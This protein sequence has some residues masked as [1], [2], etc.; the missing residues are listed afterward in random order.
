MDKPNLQPSK[1]EPKKRPNEDTS[2]Q[3]KP[4]SKSRGV[5]SEH[6]EVQ[7]D[8]T[9]STKESDKLKNSNANL[10]KK[11]TPRDAHAPKRVSKKAE[12]PK[13]PSPHQV[14]P[15]TPAPVNRKSKKADTQNVQSQKTDQRKLATKPGHQPAKQRVEPSLKQPSQPRK[16]LAPKQAAQSSKP[17]QPKKMLAPKQA[18][19]SPTPSKDAETL[20]QLSADIA[21]LEE[22]IS[23]LPNMIVAPTLEAVNSYI[24]PILSEISN[25][26]ALPNQIVGPTLEVT[27]SYISPIYDELAKLPNAIVTPTLEAVHSYIAPIQQEIAKVQ[28]MPNQILT[29]TLK[30]ISESINPVYDGIGKIPNL[31]LEPL[32]SA[33]NDGINP[34]YDEIGKIPNLVLEPLLSAV[35]DG[36]NPIYDEVGKIPNLVLEPL[37]SVVSDGINPI[38]DEIGKIPNL[39]VTPTLDAIHEYIDPIYKTSARIEQSII[40]IVTPDFRKAIFEETGSAVQSEAGSLLKPIQDVLNEV[41]GRVADDN[42]GIQLSIIEQDT[43]GPFE[44]L[45]GQSWFQSII[46]RRPKPENLLSSDDALSNLEQR[47]P[48]RYPVWKKCFDAGG[49]VYI[50]DPSNNCAHWSERRAWAFKNYVRRNACGNILDIGCGPYGDPLYLRGIDDRWLTGMEP[51][52]M[53]SETRFPIYT[54][55]NEKLPFGDHAFDTVVNSTAIDHCIDLPEAIAE[56]ARIIRPG[57]RF[58]I[59]YANVE[60][61]EDPTRPFEGALDRFHLFHNNDEWFM[62]MMSKHFRILDRKSI[63]AGEKVQ[64]VFAVFEPLH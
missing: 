26:N 41:A 18:A 44:P 57:G 34:I 7:Q 25:L 3:L 53:Q 10:G 51:L 11:T 28:G 52:P 42:A 8:R 58:V 22:K 2:S 17:S 13:K 33:V 59:W 20:R 63:R 24:A 46:N 35:N 29:P 16:T 14:K 47:F 36:I 45:K 1:S 21:A 39:V 56:T 49:E 19:Q 6:P 64:D 55:F 15:K 40:D 30:A 43:D 61:A 37:L 60:G 38:Y 12:S 48:E 50:E 4:S 5:K 32:L 9:G 31:V 62:P 23:S 27:H 54:G